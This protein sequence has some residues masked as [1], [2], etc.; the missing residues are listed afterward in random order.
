MTK[1][2]L[3]WT[4]A[5]LLLASTIRGPFLANNTAVAATCIPSPLPKERA[6]PTPIYPYVL[7]ALPKTKRIVTAPKSAPPMTLSNFRARFPMT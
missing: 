7:E 6:E 2:G 1:P 4:V 3:L 5:Q